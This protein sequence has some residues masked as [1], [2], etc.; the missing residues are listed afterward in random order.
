MLLA[1]L[2]QKRNIMINIFMFASVFGILPEWVYFRG[3]R[4]RVT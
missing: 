1:K 2:N 4:V 3:Q